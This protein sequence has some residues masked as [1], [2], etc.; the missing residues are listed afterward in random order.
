MKNIKDYLIQNY[1]TNVHLINGFKY[2]LRIYTLI[3]SLDPL[4]VYVYNEG[5]VRFAT[6]PYQ[7]RLVKHH[8]NMTFNSNENDDSLNSP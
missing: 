2:D 4:R 7:P 3:S 6:Q 8:H 5:L 1:I